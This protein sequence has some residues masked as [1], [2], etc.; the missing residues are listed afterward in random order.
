MKK[1]AKREE[2]G[3]MGQQ[4]QV[5]RSTSRDSTRRW[6]EQQQMPTIGT[7]KSISINSSQT[8]SRRLSY[9]KIRAGGVSVLIL[10]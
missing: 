10:A 6:N 7:Q 8:V 9:N 4:C 5:E 1:Q 2:S 3:E